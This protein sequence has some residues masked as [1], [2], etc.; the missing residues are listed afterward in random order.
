MKKFII[1]ILLL[2]PTVVVAENPH[3]QGGGTTNNN[4][5]NNYYTAEYVTNSVVINR[6][7]ALGLAAS[8]LNFERDTESMQWAIAAGFYEDEDA[9]SFGL[10]KRISDTKMLL[11]GS[12]S[13]TNKT[14][15]Y[16]FGLSGR[17]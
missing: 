10:A 14:K 9:M 1:L 12:V 11:N 8:G 13:V 5:T 6:S 15:G 4:T 3:N 16:S 2:A 17:F 7:V